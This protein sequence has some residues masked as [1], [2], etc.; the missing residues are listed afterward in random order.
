MKDNGTW[1]TVNEKR[2]K[3]LS[4]TLRNMNESEK[5]E[6]PVAK[7]E[8]AKVSGYS[9]LTVKI[10]TLLESIQKQKI[11][12]AELALAEA[13]KQK[14]SGE[15]N[16]RNQKTTGSVLRSMIGELGNEVS[17]D[18]WLTEAPE[19]YKSLWESLTPEVQNTINGQSKFYKLE[20]AYQIKNFWQTRNLTSGAKP[21]NE[22]SVEKAPIVLP[23]LGY[24]ESY[25][26]AVKH[27]L[28]KFKK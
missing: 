2:S 24:N 23:T 26:E 9:D 18:K 1:S 21:I 5:T 25:L 27:G 11:D 16:E 19:E 13:R 12:N 6:K 14:V 15:L 4:K 28:D 22:S 20:T 8:K 10:D 17:S 3:S 7:K